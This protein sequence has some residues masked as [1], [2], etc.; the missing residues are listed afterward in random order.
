MARTTRAEDL[1][2]VRTYVYRHEAEVGKAILDA[3]SIDAMIQADDLGGLN[4]TIGASTGGVRLLV[5][6]TNERE[7]RRLVSA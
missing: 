3:H 1:V 2:V 7:A 4:P 5:R 6:R